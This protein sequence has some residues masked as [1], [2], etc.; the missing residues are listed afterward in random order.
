MFKVRV[1]LFLIITMVACTSKS[2]SPRLGGPLCPEMINEPGVIVQIRDAVTNEPAGE[3]A[4]GTVRDGNYE[5]TMQ[6]YFQLATD[7][8][9]LPSL[10]GAF[11]RPGTYDVLVQKPGYADWSAQGV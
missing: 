1:L 6:P 9:P 11:D 2:S 5:E 4:T 8:T 10:A 3:G 7:G